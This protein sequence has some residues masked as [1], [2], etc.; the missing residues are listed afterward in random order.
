MERGYHTIIKHFFENR[1]SRSIEQKLHFNHSSQAQIAHQVHLTPR[2]LSHLTRVN[3]NPFENN[4]LR[5]PASPIRLQR[6]MKADKGGCYV[7][8]LG[9]IEI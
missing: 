6:R 2:H 4:H 5:S 9:L 7:K 3:H 8:T 1:A